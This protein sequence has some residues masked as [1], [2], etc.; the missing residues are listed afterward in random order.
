MDLQPSNSV[1]EFNCKEREPD[2]HF[3]IP[4]DNR[5]Y[6]AEIGYDNNDEWL[7]IAR[8]QSVFVS[9][10]PADAQKTVVPQ[11]YNENVQASALWG[12]EIAAVESTGTGVSVSAGIS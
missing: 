1:Q 6:T 11:A 5:E 12:Q 3:P 2:L 4:A 7:R 10:T 9:P 8:S